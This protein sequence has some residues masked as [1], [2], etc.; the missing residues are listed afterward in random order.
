[1]PL[2][3][4]CLRGSVRRVTVA[5]AL[6]VA[7]ACTTSISRAQESRKPAGAIAL[8]DLTV[9]FEPNQGQAQQPARFVARASRLN[10]AL[11]PGGIDLLLA[12]PTKDLAKLSLDFVGA[13]A[14]AKIAASDRQASYSNYILGAD[15]SRWLAHVPNF[16]RVTYSGIYPGV[17]VAFHGNGRQLEHDFVIAPG[18][19]HQLIRLRVEGPERIQLQKN[20]SLRLV[21]P[22][23]NLTF[24]PPEAYQNLAGA[25]KAVASHFVLLGKNEFG[26]SVADYDRSKALTIDP[27]LTY[28][29]YLADVSVGMYGVATDAA[30]DT[31]LTGLVF[32]T[33][34][35]VTP[36]AFQK[37]CSSCVS[38][39][40]QPDVFVSKINSTGTALVYSTFLGGSD[41]DQPAGI[42]VDAAGNA[43]VAGYTE[44]TDFPLKNP[45]PIGIM[46]F[47]TQYAFITSFT[48]DGSALNYS[49]I[50]GG[51]SQN[52]PS[53]DTYAGAV[54]LD[55]SGNA[56]IAGTTDSPVFPTT[57][58]ALDLVQP[59]YPKSV[60]FVS[61][62]LTGGTLGYS[63]L[64]GD[65]FPQNPGAGP[66][67][68]YGI[69]VD[70]SGSAY[71]TG[72]A[73]TLWPTTSGAFQTTIPGLAPYSA[74]FV[75]K[76]SP[77]AS[78]LAYSTFLGDG[79]YAAGI[80]V[81]PTTNEAFVTGQY[82][83]TSAGNDFPTTPNAFE[84]SIGTG[85]CASFFTEFSADGSKLV[86]SSYFS[87][88]L[89]GPTSFTATSGIALDSAQNIWLVGSTTSPQFPLK[90]PL[91]SIPAELYS[92][93]STTAFLT[94]FDAAGK[95]LTFSSYFG[96]TQ[97]GGTIAGIAIDPNNKAHV[98]GT[99]GDALFTTPGAYLGSVSAPPP[100]VQNLYGYAAVVDANTAAPS[101]CFTPQQLE[102]GNVLL[103]TAGTSTLTITNCGNAAMQ[104]SAV[105]SSSP[106]FTIPA[107]S[108]TCLQ[109]VAANA[110]C[111]VAVVFTPTA[112]GVVTAT[113]TSNAPVSA[114]MVMAQGVG[115][116]PQIYLQTTSLTFDPQF[117]GQTSPQQLLVIGNSGGVPLTINLAQTSISA[118]FAY[119]QSGC[120]QP[121]GPSAGCFFYL[122]FTPAS[123]GTLNGTLKIASNDP[124]N[125]IVSVSLSGIGY[126]SYPL[127][128]FNT[129]SAPTIQAG[130]AQVSLQVYGMNFF[131]GSVVLVGGIAEPTTYQNSTM[132]TATLAASLVA[133]I[134]ELQVSVL[135][136]TPGGG[137]SAPQIITVYQSLPLTANAMVYEP[138]SQLLFASIGT[139]S[140]NNPN[141]IAV[142]NP[143][144][145][146]VTK[147]LPVGNDP[148]HLAVSDDGQYLYVA[149]D[150]DHTIQR[151]NLSTFAIE[152]TFALPTDS[153][154]GQLTVADM[155]VVPGSPFTVVVALF[156]GADPAEDGIALFNAGG[157]VNWL[158]NDYP[159]YVTV[160]SFAFIG[161]PPV[162]YSL[163]ISLST[164]TAPGSFG[165]FTI[166]GAGI[167]QQTPS[168]PGPTQLATGSLLASDNKLLYTNDGQVWNPPSTLLG[169]YGSSL[170]DV[171]S[172]VPDDALGRT[173]FLNTFSSY[174]QYEATSVDAYDQSTFDLVGSVPF[175]SSAAYG[176][177]VVALNRWGSNGF[178]FVVNNF[179][180]VPTSNQIILFRSSIAYAS[181][182]TNP[183][184]ALTTLGSSSVAAGGAAFALSVQGSNFVSGSVVRWNG[185]ARATSVVSAT[186]L[187]ASIPASDIAQPG[188][189]QIEVANPAPGGGTSSPLTLTIT[190]APASVSLLPATLTFASQTVGTQSAALTVTLQNPGGATLAVSNIQTSGDFA[191]TNNCP[192][193][194]A[195]LAS[196]AITVTFTP[197]ASGARL[198]TLTVTDNAANSPQTVP[199]SGTGTAPD[200]NFGTGGS[201]TTSATVTVGQTA[202]YSL[203]IVSGSGSSGVV[204]LTCTQA[205]ENAN[206]SV[207]P[208][209]LTLTTGG[210]QSFTVS[211]ATSTATSAS[212]ATHFSIA[213]LGCGF[214]CLFGL[215]LALRRRNHLQFSADLLR[216]MLVGAIS[217]AIL[218]S[219][220]SCG[221][222]STSQSTPPSDTPKG[223]YTLQVVATEG[224][225]SHSQPITLVVK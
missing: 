46:G 42:A 107:A 159:N 135:N 14:N 122:T 127:P 214:F 192:A 173:F 186:Q 125:P 222:G 207:N 17:D 179:A 51:G 193:S 112:V 168:T 201:N 145:G 141:T 206:C 110:S 50:L 181:S 198:G 4:L 5:V 99:T 142:I 176:P 154:F 103:Q 120:N 177:N 182:G 165:V 36:N 130:S 143:A 69:A 133:N 18:A 158:P 54:A 189:A 197:T 217:L 202:T 209:S 60:G 40:G 213:T 149:L 56:Y 166:D 12:G 183:V 84:P 216:M 160:D 140:T 132:I 39:I 96:G 45:I 196:C 215:P 3:L 137:A 52:Q 2:R 25:K 191:E 220:S 118:G 67:G 7:A 203:S 83:A 29:T 66:V 31:F 32:S 124:A 102:F 34:F 70:T 8:A 27:V 78:S 152:K 33:N 139:G 55:S 87:P 63:A 113:I 11:R 90:Y 89:S 150:G 167:H 9:N 117:I 88:D 24:D 170:F 162:V 59:V 76:L 37:T 6:F 47:A 15:P 105:Q 174:G 134:G 164:P 104:I 82:T 205:P 153:L 116:V 93:D 77:N 199:L 190:T 204:M 157:L 195:A 155:K 180:P 126:S 41:Y 128:T 26:F 211:V 79:G 163:P 49:S 68:V 35:P 44:S 218:A 219:L 148:N 114:A 151:I 21:Y 108:N 161:T 19:D 224:T 115:A 131:P 16:G 223:T 22:D 144:A 28:S 95:N 64:L 10:A 75:T 80:T 57:A 146:Q 208:S 123:A 98:A 13:A 184:P 178:A 71:I 65:T 1:M 43:V 212:L 138:V 106:L 94:R 58:G 136:P 101:L 97:Q 169:T 85:C 111:N 119:T 172:V 91:Q 74:P 129:V 72:S 210:T 62:F 20:G 109:S 61:K 121:L 86:Y 23:G 171:T 188:T 156:R 147:Y 73:G 200:F 48:P 53:S 175:L 100:N 187:T 225:T 185:S 81:N 30:G 194:V 221:G 92:A 38:S